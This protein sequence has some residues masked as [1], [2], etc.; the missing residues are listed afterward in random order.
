MLNEIVFISV[1]V[2]FITIKLKDI[3]LRQK[4]NQ[5][6]ERRLLLS[7][8]LVVLFLLSSV[9]FPFPQS[10]YW[11]IVLGILFLVVLISSDIIKL[12]WKRQLA[13]PFNKRVINVLFYSLLFVFIN[14]YI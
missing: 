14:I 5:N 9:T 4:L 7:G 11:F 8:G 1:I 3:S 6:K 13:L 10:L 2:A 12:E